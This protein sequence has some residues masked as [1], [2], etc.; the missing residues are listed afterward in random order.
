MS[1]ATATAAA[2]EQRTLLGHPLGLYVLFFTEMWERFSFYS[3]KGILVLFMVKAMQYDDKL[4]NGVY[5]AYLG[6]VYSAPFLGGMIADRL[7]GQRR[8]IVWGG[9]LMAIAHFTLAANALALKYGYSLDVFSPLFYLGLGFL[10]A[11]NGFF[12]PNISTIVGSLYEQGD[13]RRDGAFT[14][15]YMG[16]NVGATLASISCQ[17]AETYDWYIGF[18]LAGCGMLV[19]QAI[20]ALGKKWLQGKGM[21]PRPADAGQPATGVASK[22]AGL[23]AAVLAFVPLAAFAMSRPQRVQDIAVYIAVPILVYLV[24]EA[25]RGQPEERGRM[26][27]IIVLS[28]FSMLFWGF[29]ELAGSALNIFAD[30][31]VHRL[32]SIGSW[33]WEAKASFLTSSINPILVIL[34]GYPFAKLWVWLDRVGK[35]PSSPLKFAFGLIQLAAGFLVLYAGA[36]QAGTDGR[37]NLSWLILGFFL[38]TTGELCLSPVGLSTIT[39]LSPARLVGMFMGVWFLAS[40]L[41]GVFAGKVGGYAADYGFALVFRNIAIATAAASVLL[42]IL[43]PFLKR[44]MYGVK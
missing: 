12:K 7:L 22:T 21:P 16:I 38:F 41:G 13:A 3:M 27:V 34:L 37:C 43:V 14:I 36:A 20:F 9:I 8:A 6:F 28:T 31:H 42:F 33:T 23:L 25:M 40:A 18:L 5:G 24:Y 35:E 10:A 4:S 2:P 1:N 30:R 15:F 11:G 26:I 17:I 39:K 29:F 19:G 44:L 32:I